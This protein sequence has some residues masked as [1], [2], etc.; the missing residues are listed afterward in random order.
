MGEQNAVTESP[1]LSLWTIENALVELI[2]AREEVEAAAGSPD[3]PYDSERALELQEIDKAIAEYIRAEVGKVDNIRGFLK[4]AEMM[5]EAAREEAAAQTARA[6][7]WEKRIDA[8]K[9]RVRDVMLEAGS[10]RLDGRTGAFLIK[11]NGGKQP[12][13]V[14]NEAAVPEECC[15]YVGWIGGELWRRLQ[16]FL[17]IIYGRY[18]LAAS[19][20]RLTRTVDNEWTRDALKTQCSMCGGLPPHEA[21]DVCP[22]CGG[23]GTEPVPG[24]RLGER[25][26]HLEV[27]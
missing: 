27:K 20:F 24:A 2:Q 21:A 26:Q 12:L 19:D 25:G 3:D 5:A 14:D 1:K 8:V 11:G 9:D 4:H 18:G 23:S 7:A 22:V 6:R 13:I 15:K 16:A 10:K 17:P